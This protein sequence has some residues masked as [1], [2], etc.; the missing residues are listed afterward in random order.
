L[1]LNSIS[2]T[3]LKSIRTLKIVFG[4]GYPVY[5]RG[6]DFRWRGNEFSESSLVDPVIFEKHWE[7]MWKIL[8]AAESLKNLHIVIFD[9]GY[10]YPEEQLLRP[11]QSLQ[12]ADLRVQ[13]PWRHDYQPEL[14]LKADDSYSFQ[15]IRPNR[16]DMLVWQWETPPPLPKQSGLDKIVGYFIKPKPAVPCHVNRAKFHASLARQR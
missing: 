13:L 14:A 11:L 7:S 9:R 2:K 8:S 3:A 16:E 5:M 15:I 10:R 12:I 4:S 1:F 6:R